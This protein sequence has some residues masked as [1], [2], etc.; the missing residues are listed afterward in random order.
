MN[1]A[2]GGNT[3]WRKFRYLLNS[4][5]STRVRTVVSPTGFALDQN[6]KSVFNSNQ[7]N[8]PELKDRFK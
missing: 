1:S 8:G 2:V 3:V 6:V 7:Y 5:S 4:T